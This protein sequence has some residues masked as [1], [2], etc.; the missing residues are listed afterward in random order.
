MSGFHIARR[1]VTTALPTYTTSR[2]V[3]VTALAKCSQLRV[4]SITR[5]RW[6]VRTYLVIG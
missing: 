1:V 5:Y 4:G 6:N 3:T 2:D